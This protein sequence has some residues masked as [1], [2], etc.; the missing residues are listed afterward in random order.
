M[1]AHLPPL[2]RARVTF[3]HLE[4]REAGQGPALVLLHGI[5]SG[6]A[7]WQAQLEAFA[8]RH[9]V[10]AWDA[11][12]Y[13][14]SSPLPIDRPLAADYAR[15]LDALLDALAVREL[16]L[17][18]HSLGAMIAAAFAAGSTASVRA[19]VL[20]SPARGYGRQPALLQAAKWAERVDAVTRLGPDQLAR[21]RSAALC[22]PT[23][24]AETL[25][26]VRAAMARITVQGYTQAAHMLA[27]DDLLSHPVPP[28]VPVAVLSGELDRITPPE[29]CA[30]VARACGSDLVALP[31]LAHACY[32]EGPEAFN[33][34]L[35]RCLPTAQSA[36]P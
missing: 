5:G 20:A 1:A 24:S 26:R 15:A 32:V 22:S 10:I 34:A 31:G 23:A 11:P 8:P 16:M 27:H 12:G 2:Q 3:G 25:E 19:L 4:W 30:E 33:R 18:G 36:L 21:Q 17:V 7:S 9:R 35:A 14:D 6:A 29:A 13:G 28:G